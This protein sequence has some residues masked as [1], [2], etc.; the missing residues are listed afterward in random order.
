MKKNYMPVLAVPAVLIVLC[1]FAGCDSGGS[2]SPPRAE[3]AMQTYSNDSDPGYAEAA[4]GSIDA[5]GK[6]TLKLPVISQW[7]GIPIWH[8][9]MGLTADPSDVRTVYVG[10]LKVADEGLELIKT[11]GTSSV[12][13]IYADKDALITGKA[14][15][16]GTA[17]YVNLILKKGWNSVIE[18]PSGSNRTMASGSPDD[19]Y[20]WVVSD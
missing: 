5:D 10:S 19:T 16:N 3:T 12:S 11:N 17:V 15:E 20:K 1:A 13:Y 6:L 7:T 14:G 4:L 9:K 2:P 8:T 18:G